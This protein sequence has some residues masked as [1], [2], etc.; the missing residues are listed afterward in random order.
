MFED[1]ESFIA[2]VNSETPRLPANIPFGAEVQKTKPPMRTVIKDAVG[3]LYGKDLRTKIR[4]PNKY[5]QQ[6]TVGG[7]NEELRS[8]GGIIFPYTPQIQFEL[9]AEYSSTTP[10]HSNFQ[11]NFYKNSTIGTISVSGKF[12]VQNKEDAK[13]YISTVH[14]L[15]ALTRMRAGGKT[16]DA[17]SGAP[18]PVCRLDAHGEMILNNVPV[19]IQTFRIELP[20]SV[21]YFTIPGHHQYGP[22]S[23]PTV[24]TIAVT[25]LPM[26]SRSE[27][28]KFNVTGYV[29]NDFLGKGYI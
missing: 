3:N 29:A 9:K 12:T 2:R 20:D 1:P 24:S 27:M 13:I 26:Y 16:G 21:D 4:V 11:I 10:L 14:L 6:H 7:D 18:P 19:A 22:T 28:Q 8:H 15:K 25:C 17:D 23:V 5:L